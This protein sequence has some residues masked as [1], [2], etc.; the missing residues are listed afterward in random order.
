MA[1]AH[2]AAGDGGESPVCGSWTPPGDALGAPGIEE[3]GRHCGGPQGLLSPRDPPPHPAV[4]PESGDS[5][6]ICP[7]RGCE[8]HIAWKFGEP[9]RSDCDGC[10]SSPQE[11]RVLGGG[12]CGQA[13]KP[14]GNR[15]DWSSRKKKREQEA[16]AMHLLFIRMGWQKRMRQAQLN[17]E[18]ADSP[19]GVW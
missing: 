17:H 11:D 5:C 7:H 14:D 2:A 8:S 3:L 12:V 1:A 13:G 18:K 4:S 10:R 19:S 6:H 9:R 15:T 16:P